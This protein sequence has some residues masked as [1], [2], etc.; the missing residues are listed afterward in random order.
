MNSRKEDFMG[1]FTS[2]VNVLPL[3]PRRS[4]EAVFFAPKAALRSD[5]LHPL[6]FIH[7]SMLIS[8][9]S[10]LDAT[11][12]CQPPTIFKPAIFRQNTG[13]VDIQRVPYFRQTWGI[14]HR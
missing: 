10:Q 7:V 13:A 14:G 5:T 9:T 1:R 11:A 8:T 6:R 3:C 2:L 4:K 12:P